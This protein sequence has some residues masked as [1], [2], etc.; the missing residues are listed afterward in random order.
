MCVAQ[1]YSFN[2]VCNLLA[3]T[4]PEGGL[5]STST[6]PEYD[7][8]YIDCALEAFASPYNNMFHVKE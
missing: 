3:G 4:S 7:P 5:H 2:D 8:L 6:P 1:H